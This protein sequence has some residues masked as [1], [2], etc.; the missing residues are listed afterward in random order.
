MLHTTLRHQTHN[1]THHC[2]PRNRRKARLNELLTSVNGSPIASSTTNA[3]DSMMDESMF[4]NSMSRSSRRIT[5]RSGVPR[6]S[7]VNQGS[8]LGGLGSAGA[9]I[10]RGFILESG[11]MNVPIDGGN[12]IVELDPGLSPAVMDQFNSEQKQQLK[13]ELKVMQDKLAAFMRQIK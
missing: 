2:S 8:L 13:D 3:D 5:L 11:T 7:G 4:Q 12:T 1:Q 6:E 9:G 10:G